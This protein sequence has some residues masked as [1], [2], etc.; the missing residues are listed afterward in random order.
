MT[1][2]AILYPL[3]VQVAL[4]IV[5]MSWLGI[6]RVK[7]AN[8]GDVRLSDI[9]LDASG[10]PDDVIK[11]ANCVLNQFQT[12][13]LF[14]LLC[15]LL[16][17]TGSLDTLHVVLA[18]IFVAGRAVHAFVHTGSNTI[19]HRFYAFFISFVALSIMWVRF[20]SDI[21]LKGL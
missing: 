6:A 9:A 17:I 11:I 1:N 4:T 13:L 8:R 19:R 20:G 14:Y 21:I 15:V 12:P 16:I 10:W 18:W 5:L 3:L 2:A 7:A